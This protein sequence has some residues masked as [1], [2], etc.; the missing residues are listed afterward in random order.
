ML[1]VQ[2][3]EQLVQVTMLTPKFANGHRAF[4]TNPL[5]EAIRDNQDVFSGVFAWYTSEFN[6]AQGGLVQKA[7]GMYVSGDYFRTLGVRQEAGR[8]F[9][10]SD[11][12]RGCAGTAVLSYGFWRD[13]L[14][15]AVSAIGAT[16]PIEGH[17]FQ[18]VGVT[19][20][21]FFGTEVGQT[22]DIAVPICS[23]ALINS[24][25]FSLDNRSL[26]LFQMMGAQ[27]QG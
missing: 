13:H 23:A 2:H 4:Y 8:L 1:P 27:S 26:W 11:D 7:R 14:G 3:P 17:P 22:F 18:I 6:L 21:G 16:I 19:P 25:H 5:W 20:P 10:V 12:L 9:T 15:G 24:K